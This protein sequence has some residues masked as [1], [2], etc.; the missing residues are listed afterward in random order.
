MRAR[1]RAHTCWP[2]RTLLPEVGIPSRQPIEFDLAN[3]LAGAQTDVP[4]QAMSLSEVAVRV[5]QLL[6]EVGDSVTAEAAYQVVYR[7]L[8]TFASHT[9]LPLLDCYLPQDAGYFVRVARQ[10]GTAQTGQSFTRNILVLT[11]MHAR[12]TLALTDTPALI[13][14]AVE[15]LATQPE[16]E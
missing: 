3:A 7:A 13:A 5:D 8:S 14:T 11:A 16:G 15:T 2:P 6:D 4:A 12:R 10:A 1:I 9:T